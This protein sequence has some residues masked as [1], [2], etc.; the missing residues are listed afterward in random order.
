MNEQFLPSWTEEE[1]QYLLSN[2]K[3]KTVG[4][5]ANNL[6]R[7][8]SSVKTKMRYMKLKPRPDWTEEQIKYLRKNYGKKPLVDVAEKLNKSTSAIQ[9][10]AHRIGIDTG[11]YWSKKEERYLVKWRGRKTNAEIAKALKRSESSVRDKVKHMELDYFLDCRED[12]LHSAEIARLVGVSDWVINDK[13]RHHGLKS[14]KISKYRMTKVEDLYSF[15]QEHP[16]LWDATKCERWYFTNF[17]WFEEKRTKD[18]QMMID[19]RW[20]KITNL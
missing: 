5:M 8:Y 3:D 9:M 6:G 20:G 4:E 1:K 16:N 7:S 2:H 19:E 17:E 14:E 10:K 11:R 13:W 15:M 12:Y 18:F